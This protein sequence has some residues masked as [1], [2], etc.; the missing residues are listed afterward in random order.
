MSSSGVILEMS[1]GKLDVLVPRPPTAVRLPVPLITG[2]SPELDALDSPSMGPA[3]SVVTGEVGGCEGVRGI[4]V[5]IGASVGDETSFGPCGAGGTEGAGGIGGTGGTQNSPKLCAALC[6]RPCCPYFASPTV[7]HHSRRVGSE[8]L[9]AMA[10]R[11][12]YDGI[13]CA[14]GSFLASITSCATVYVYLGRL[15][16]CFGCAFA[17]CCGAAS[18]A[19]LGNAGLSDTTVPGASGS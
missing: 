4:S 8:Q 7:S 19:A 15:R 9:L 6:S 11:F 14:L 12:T 17:G 10:D 18:G 5:G 2:I 16:G 13:A 1:S 3:S